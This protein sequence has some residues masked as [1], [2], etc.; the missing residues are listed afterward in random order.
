[1]SRLLSILQVNAV[2]LRSVKCTLG[3]LVGA[4]VG[5][6]ALASR[7]RSLGTPLDLDGAGTPAPPNGAAKATW[8]RPPAWTDLFATGL[9]RAVGAAAD[10]AGGA[11]DSLAGERCAHGFVRRGDDRGPL[12][13][14]QPQA[15]RQGVVSVHVAKG[16]RSGNCSTW[17]I[18]HR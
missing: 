18:P 1:V 5:E 6:E 8:Q 11:T 16:T 12:Q 14:G 17:F 3:V 10:V 15:H 2:T 13:D 7:L 4:A 9:A